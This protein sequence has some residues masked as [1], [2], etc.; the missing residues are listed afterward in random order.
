MIDVGLLQVNSI[1]LVHDKDQWLEL[2]SVLRDLGAKHHEEDFDT[3]RPYRWVMREGSRIEW[4]K[5]NE[6]SAH[7]SSYSTFPILDFEDLVITTVNDID[8]SD[9]F[10]DVF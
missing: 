5:G 4:Y 9:L 10:D 7:S 6:A 8:F 3:D 2:Q 1:V